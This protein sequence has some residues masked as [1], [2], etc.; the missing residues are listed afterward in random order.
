METEAIVSTY[1]LE[2]GKPVPSFNHGKVQTRLGSQ[3]LAYEDEYVTISELNLDLKGDKLVPDLSVFPYRKSQ[4]DQDISWVT[5]PPALVIEII[6]PSQ[7]INELFNKAKR[8]FKGGVPTYWLVIP[9]LQ[10]I[11]ILQPDQK[12]RYFPDGMVEDE[13]TGVQVSVDQLFR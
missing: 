7:S 3:L 4:W 12:P 9:P 13:N 10:T 11:V 8:Y 5:E 2:R 1:E 6:S